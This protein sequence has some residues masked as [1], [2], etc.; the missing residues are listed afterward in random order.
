M[1]IDQLVATHVCNT[2]NS[3]TITQVNSNH[4]CVLVRSENFYPTYL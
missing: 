2:C 4:A 3:L 1:M